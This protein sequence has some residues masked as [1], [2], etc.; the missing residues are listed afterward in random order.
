MLIWLA[1]YPRS[2]NTLLRM[3]LNECF[4]MPSFG[5]GAATD[6]VE[7]GFWHSTVGTRRYSRERSEM[8]A[9]ARRSSDIVTVKTHD[10]APAKTD[11]AIYI[12]RDGRAAIASYQRYLRDFDKVEFSL[13]ELAAGERRPYTWAQH[14]ERWTA[15]PGVLVLRYED[16]V[17]EPPLGMIGE[18]LGVPAKAK[19]SLSFRDLHNHDQRFFGVGRNGPGIEAVERTC[20]RTFWLHNGAT[21]RKF[22]YRRSLIHIALALIRDRQPS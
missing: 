7:G 3:I 4:A 22:G 5:A 2:G 18:Y 10:E 6:L 15:H 16:L 13:A 9:E 11:R 21:M 19:F 8:L 20:A 17:T 14:V 1:S 12:L